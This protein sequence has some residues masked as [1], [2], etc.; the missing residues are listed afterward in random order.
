MLDALPILQTREASEFTFSGEIA[1]LRP[2]VA[3][4]RAVNRAIRND[5]LFPDE[6]EGLSFIDDFEGASLKINLLNPN[7]WNLA[8]APAAKIGRASCRERVESR[9]GG[10]GVR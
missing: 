8:A 7:R 4:T 6:E 3:E 1:Q 9:R 5:E 2:G 10:G